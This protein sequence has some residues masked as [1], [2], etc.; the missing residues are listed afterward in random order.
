MS[1]ENNQYAVLSTQNQISLRNIPN[2]FGLVWMD[3]PQVISK[4]F[5]I[6][7]NL[8]LNFDGKS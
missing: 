1:I 4:F 3:C 7:R 8:L 5:H 6:G 2:L